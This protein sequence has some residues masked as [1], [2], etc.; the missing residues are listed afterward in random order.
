[1][2]NEGLR[3]F[4]FFYLDFFVFSFSDGGICS[5]KFRAVWEKTAA[6]LTCRR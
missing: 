2:L 4:V 6:L 3:L 1:M 5:S